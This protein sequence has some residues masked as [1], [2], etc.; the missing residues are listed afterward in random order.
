MALP[1]L[2]GFAERGL[3][4]TQALEQLKPMGLT[5]NRQRMLDV[6]AALQNKIDPERSARLVGQD[7]PIPQELHNLAVNRQTHNYQYE[8]GAFDE[9]GQPLGYVTV[10]STIPLAASEIRTRAS[11]LMLRPDA[12]SPPFLKGEVVALSIEKAS[13]NLG[14]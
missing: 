6:Y 1:F 7:V 13:V 4:A 3:S 14:V 11:N 8:V 5:F 12:P 10:G 9:T 2:R